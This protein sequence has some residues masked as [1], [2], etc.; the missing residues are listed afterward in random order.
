MIRFSFRSKNLLILFL[1]L[2]VSTLV[3]IILE[4][5]ST[6][7]GLVGSFYT[8]GGVNE[9]WVQAKLQPWKALYDYGEIFTVGFAFFSAIM[10]LGAM[11]GKVS[12]KFVK[13][14]LVVVLTFLLGPGLLINGIL[15]NYWGRP[16]PSEVNVLGGDQEY[17]KV[18]QPA[19]SGG[20]KSFTCGHCSVAF[21]MISAASFFPTN[22]AAQLAVFFASAA[23]GI[24]MGIARMAQ[25]GHFAGDVLWSFVLTV[26]VWRLIHVL[27]FRSP[28]IVNAEKENIS[29]RPDPTL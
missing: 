17:R 14:C 29:S 6:D 27:V 18:W 13:P 4:A 25:G 21:A 10:L 23:L 22:A 28:E 26:I 7:L 11:I 3:T 8:P 24:V 15:K 1:L 16:R 9:G 2:F 20:G 5:D 12:R 19:G